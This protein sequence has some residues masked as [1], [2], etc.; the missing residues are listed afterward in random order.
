VK[1]QV[2]SKTSKKFKNGI[3]FVFTLDSILQLNN[4]LNFYLISEFDYI[5]IISLWCRT[6][7]SSRILF[8]LQY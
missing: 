3:S 4:K 8:K 2:K 5:R 6:Q 1:L 7:F